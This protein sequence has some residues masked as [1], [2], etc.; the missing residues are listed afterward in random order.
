[1]N[2]VTYHETNTKN[3]ILSFFFIPLNTLR[4]M[5]QLKQNKTK[6]FLDNFLQGLV[7]VFSK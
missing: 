2:N 5:N 4:G 1:M 7:N 6:H 3:T